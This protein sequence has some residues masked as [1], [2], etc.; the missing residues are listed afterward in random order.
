MNIY[1]YEYTYPPHQSTTSP[2]ALWTAP[3]PTAATVAPCGSGAPPRPRERPL[4][5]GDGGGSPPPG[6][7][8]HP[9]A[10]VAP[11]NV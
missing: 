7:L 9:R 1:I 4:A 5:H 11:F 2:H 3:S 8:G 10:T 6:P